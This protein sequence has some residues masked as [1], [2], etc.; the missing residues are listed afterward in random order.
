VAKE[1]APPRC[2]ADRPYP[3]LDVGALAMLLLAFQD[4]PTHHPRPLRLDARTPTDRP[5]VP[6]GRARTCGGVVEERRW[7]AH[8][9]GQ[10]RRIVTP[11]VFNIQK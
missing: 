7:G 8:V 2:E 3:N 6:P 4:S 9:G 11:M 5:A 10:A 1:P